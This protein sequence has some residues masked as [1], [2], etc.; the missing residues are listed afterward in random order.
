MIRDGVSLHLFVRHEAYDKQENLLP[1]DEKCL[2]G[3]KKED[4]QFKENGD[5]G[6]ISSSEEEDEQ[7]DYQND[8][9]ENSSKVHTHIF[10]VDMVARYPD[11]S[12]SLILHWGMS[13]KKV[14]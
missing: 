7:V 1:E 8:E 3:A 4:K 11:T 6:Q 2:P 12:D 10:V 14:G 13:R 5:P 9:E